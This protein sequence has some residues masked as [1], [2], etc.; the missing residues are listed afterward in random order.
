M[1]I[2]GYFVSK[3]MEVAC[4]DKPVTAVVAW[5]TDNEDF[6]EAGQQKP[7]PRVCICSRR[8]H[9]EPGEFLFA[10]VNN[11]CRQQNLCREKLPVCLQQWLVALN[12]YS[13]RKY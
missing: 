4:C 10:Q 6:A 2:E 7:L 11:L 5:A 13:N 9:T 8:C 1:K 12:S 3:V